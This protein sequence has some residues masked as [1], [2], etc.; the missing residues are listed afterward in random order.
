M[1]ATRNGH[2]RLHEAAHAY[3]EVHDEGNGPFLMLVHGFLSS[4]AQWRPNL[5]GLTRFCR[6][7]L[8][9]LLGHGRSPA[10]ADSQAYTV[11]SYLAAFEDIRRQVG[12]ERWLVC[13]QS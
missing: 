7:V 4:R 10:P 11:D 13:G 1:A 8:I 6:P 2:A 9:E 12:A 3:Y 5:A